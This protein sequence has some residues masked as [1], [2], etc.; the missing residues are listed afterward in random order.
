MSMLS[1]SARWRAALTHAARQVLTAR[2]HST[3]DALE[4]ARREY[5]ILRAAAA[6]DVR[7]VR[8][9]A[10]RLHDLEQLR[11]VLAREFFVGG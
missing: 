5:L 6:I 9:S 11:A 8:K 2:W 7:A 1:A 10:Q 4:C 3:L